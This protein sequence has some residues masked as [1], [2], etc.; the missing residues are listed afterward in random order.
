M[1]C[2]YYFQC[3]SHLIDNELWHPVV[4]F[5]LIRRELLIFVHARHQF[6]IAR[7]HS[8]LAQAKTVLITSM[9]GQ[10]Y[11]LV[12]VILNYYLAL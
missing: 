7:S 1:T 6:L 5:W 2:E 12:H 4:V 3:L 8:H 11:A 9:A 10:P